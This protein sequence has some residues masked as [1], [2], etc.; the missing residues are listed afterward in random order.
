MRWMNK[1]GVRAFCVVCCILC[2]LMLPGCRSR[3]KRAVQETDESSVMNE[4]ESSAEQY[5][6]SLAVSN[7]NET[8]SPYYGIM[9]ASVMDINGSPGDSR[10]VYSFRD[11]SDPENAWSVTE[12][13]IGSIETEIIRGADVVL[14]FHGDVIMDSENIEFIAVLPD[15]T[16]S[17]KRAEGITSSNTM[18]TF[19]LITGA[20]EI[21]IF[22]KDNCRIEDGAMSTDSGDS[23]V[24]YYADGGELGN[25]PLRIYRLG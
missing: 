3:E 20:G 22:N 2:A 25:Y 17:L 6:E 12:L 8:A 19:T 23:V 5:E 15:G 7:V 10:T 13:E 1:S 16:Y 21:I 4:P 18:S 9:Y 11:K 14:L 24:V